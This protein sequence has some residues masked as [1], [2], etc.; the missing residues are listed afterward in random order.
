MNTLAEQLNLCGPLRLR[1][2]AVR[3]F[4]SSHFKRFALALCLLMTCMAQASQAIPD[5]ARVYADSWS[6]LG[7]AQMRWFGFHLYTAELW[8]SRAQ[9]DPASIYALKLTYARF[10]PGSRLSSV[11]VDEMRRIGVT[12]E[13]LL[14][15]WKLHMDKLFPDV[16]EGDTLTGVYLPGKGAV[17]YQGNTLVGEVNDPAF[18]A[19]FFGIWLDPRTREPALRL[20]LIGAR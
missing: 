7:Q 8:S 11:S 9:F 4:V 5:A 16:R 10:I 6:V 12:D 18:A 15:R 19:A 2:S 20:Q 3:G 14:A 17:F 13:A 1:V